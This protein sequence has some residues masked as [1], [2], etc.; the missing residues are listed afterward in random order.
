M[1]FIL[2]AYYV[3]AWYLHNVHVFQTSAVD[4]VAYQNLYRLS[5]A[6]TH[7]TKRNRANVAIKREWETDRVGIG[8]NPNP[9]FGF[10]R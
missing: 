5:H 9:N 2:C 10:K 7:E 1:L 8:D 6:I 3:L 4:S